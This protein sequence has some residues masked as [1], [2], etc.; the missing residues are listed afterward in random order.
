MPPNLQS[1]IL[2]I[3]IAD[4]NMPDSCIWTFTNDG[5]FSTA[6]AREITKDK[7]NKMTLLSISGTKM[8]SICNCCANPQNETADHVFMKGEVAEKIW[9]FFANPVAIKIQRGSMNQLMW[10]WWATERSNALHK[11]ICSILPMYINWEL[12]KRRGASRYGQKSYSI[13]NIIYHVNFQ[14]KILLYKHFTQVKLHLA[15]KDICVLADNYSAPVSCFPVY[16]SKPQGLQVKIN[17]DGSSI[18]EKKKAGAGGIIRDHEGR[19][20]LAFTQSIG[21]CSNNEAEIKAA[22]I[23][24]YY[25]STLGLKNVIL[26]MD[27]KLIVDMIIE[28]RKPSWKFQHK[29]EG[30][31]SRLNMLEGVAHHCYREANSVV[32][33][34]SKEGSV[35]GL[36]GVFQAPRH[37]P[38]TAIGAYRLDKCGMANFRITKKKVGIG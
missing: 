37:L 23:G 7:K 16:W 1:L 4:H 6:F 15:W 11:T 12:W 17:T 21:Y 25:C 3:H 30:I 14:V 26:E 18:K 22:Q 36:N 29:I 31:Q 10:S 20:I 2:K 13:N 38:R 5:S 34:L 8:A 28:I 24:L 19:M 32:D 27:S 33:I 9:R 35:K